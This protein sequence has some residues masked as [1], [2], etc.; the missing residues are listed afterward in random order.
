MVRDFAQKLSKIAEYQAV[1]KIW[2]SFEMAVISVE[3]RLCS[4]FHDDRK[5]S[6]RPIGRL[7]ASC[8][9]SRQTRLS[10]FPGRR[11]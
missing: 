10:H 3:W 1:T 9:G 5:W 7:F 6:E 2:A 11:H 8:D 4:V